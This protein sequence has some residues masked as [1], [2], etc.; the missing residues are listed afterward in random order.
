MDNNNQIG[1]SAVLTVGPGAT[2][3]F[4]TF[5][6]TIGQLIA[7]NNAEV[8]GQN[9]LTISGAATTYLGDGSS[10]PVRLFGGTGDVELHDDVSCFAFG[11]S[12]NGRLTY[13]GTNTFSVVMGDGGI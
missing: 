10:V 6:D 9:P 5:T 13:V 3:Q 2:F 12:L 4:L 1:D 8:F 11:L 7:Q